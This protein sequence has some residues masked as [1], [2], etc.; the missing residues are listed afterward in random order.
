[1]N[2]YTF[3]II[4]FTDFLVGFTVV[5]ALPLAWTF[6]SKSLSF[7]STYRGNVQIAILFVDGIIALGAIYMILHF[8]FSMLMLLL[9]ILLA[10]LGKFF[11]P[12]ADLLD[13][14]E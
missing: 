4:F 2:F 10:L 14:S 9:S 6:I 7:G 11:F 8:L 3:R 12:P 13:N 5:I 1:M